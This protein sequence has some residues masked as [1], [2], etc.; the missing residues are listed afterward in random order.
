MA[1]IAI[2]IHGGCGTLSPDLMGEAEW[3]QSRAHLGEALRAG[4]SILAE[5]GS[6]VAAVE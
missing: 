4:W 5:G 2:G 6:S 3:A 1:P